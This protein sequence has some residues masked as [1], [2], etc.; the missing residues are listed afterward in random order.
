MWWAKRSGRQPGQPTRCRRR[1]DN[2]LVLALF[3]SDQVRTAMRRSECFVRERAVVRVVTTRLGAADANQINGVIPANR[4]PARL[5]QHLLE[6]ADLLL[7]GGRIRR[8]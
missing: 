7:S 2:Y 3:R 5:T 4:F 8:L 1:A 6:L